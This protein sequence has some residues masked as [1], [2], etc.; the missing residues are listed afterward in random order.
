LV[1]DVHVQNADTAVKVETEGL[2]LEAIAAEMCLRGR[3]WD[4]SE[5]TGHARNLP[6][7]SGG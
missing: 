4:I 5:V 7:A 6:V 1:V 3:R 2:P